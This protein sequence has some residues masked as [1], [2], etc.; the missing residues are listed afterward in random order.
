MNHQRQLQQLYEG[1]FASMH[2]LVAFY[3]LFHHMAKQ[4][5]DFWSF[6]SFGLLGYD[7]SRTQASPRLIAR[8]YDAEEKETLCWTQPSISCCVTFAPWFLT[9]HISCSQS[10]MRTTTTA[11][12]VAGSDV[13][14]KMV[15][16]RDETLKL[17]AARTMQRRFHTRHHMFRKATHM[18][19]LELNSHIEQLV[20]IQATKSLQSSSTYLDLS[21]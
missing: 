18:T 19:E 9:I 16:L 13:R 12:P 4:V 10:I 7:M 15:H 8:L 3:V 11:S 5:Q 17:W 20:Q 21:A 1:R 6:V 14:T 2:R